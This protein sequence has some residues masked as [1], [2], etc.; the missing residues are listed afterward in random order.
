MV[1]VIVAACSEELIEKLPTQVN[2]GEKLEHDFSFFMAQDRNK[3]KELER[4]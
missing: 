1:F 3:N 4:K 2:N